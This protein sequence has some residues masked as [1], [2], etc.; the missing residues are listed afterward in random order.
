MAPGLQNLPQLILVTGKG[1]TG[2]TTCAAALAKLLAKQKKVWL[3]EFGRPEDK[4][5]S[6]LPELFGIT[7][8]DHDG[9]TLGNLTIKKLDP[10]ACLAEYVRSKIPI[11][12][13]ANI[14]FQNQVSASLLEIVPGINDILCLGKL[15]YALKN[16]DGPNHIIIDGPS[17]GHALSLCNAPRNFSAITKVGPLFKDAS[18]MS[19]YLNSK[20][21]ATVM[22]S[23]AEETPFQECQE[24]SPKFQKF[25]LKYIV[26]NRLFS[27]AYYDLQS[28]KASAKENCRLENFIR[29]KIECEKEVLGK[30]REDKTFSHLEFPFSPSEPL[31]KLE[32]LD[33]WS[34]FV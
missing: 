29:E 11:G 7:K 31:A 17:S 23:L 30:F 3:V 15:W 14:L 6:R 20:Q 32:S 9:T 8:I 34:P 28:P 16:P 33:L 5:F 1:G 13:L 25:G 22:V 21:F 24:F 10:K 18:A 19:D 12:P 4:S 2:K 27:Q 26:I